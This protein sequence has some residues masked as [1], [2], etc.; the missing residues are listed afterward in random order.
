MAEEK[1]KDRIVQASLSPNDYKAM[2][3][4]LLDNEID[5]QRQ[6]LRELIYN[7]VGIEGEIKDERN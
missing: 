7:A 6:W 2:K 3:M 5:N 4:F 1:Q